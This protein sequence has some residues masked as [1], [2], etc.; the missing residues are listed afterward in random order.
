MEWDGG[1]EMREMRAVLR[2]GRGDGYKNME[3][4][5]EGAGERFGR[6]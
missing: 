3:K 1:I 4:G 5:G 6:L 2:G